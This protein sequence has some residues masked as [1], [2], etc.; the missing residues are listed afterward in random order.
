MKIVLNRFMYQDEVVFTQFECGYNDIK[1]KEFIQDFDSLNRLQLVQKYPF[2]VCKKG[3]LG[4]WAGV[5]DKTFIGVLLNKS[6]IL[7]PYI[8]MGPM[9]TLIASDLV[10][11][12][13]AKRLYTS[14]QT[15]L[16]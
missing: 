2:Y 5:R 7:P 14:T 4:L 8:D 16:T 11:G 12:I 3:I 1:V 15:I 6:Q 9:E 13:I 10:V